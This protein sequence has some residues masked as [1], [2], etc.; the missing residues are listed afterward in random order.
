MV[1]SIVLTVFLMIEITFEVFIFFCPHQGLLL[2]GLVPIAAKM[3]Y[4]VKKNTVELIGE[5]S[6]EPGGIFL[7]ALPADIYFSPD[8][9]SRLRE[10]E[11][12]DVGEG[13]MG[14]ELAVEPE[15]ESVRAENIAEL[16]HLAALAPEN[17]FDEKF[18]LP[19]VGEREPDIVKM[20]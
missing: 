8:P 10:I 20:E 18:Q 3:Q 15:E 19:A 13:V 14:Q 6:V 12:K 5:R 11:G 4:P 7:H 2:G 17:I 1:N 9:A 16:F